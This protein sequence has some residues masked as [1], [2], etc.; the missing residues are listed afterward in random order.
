MRTLDDPLYHI[1]KFNEKNPIPRAYSKTQSL[2]RKVTNDRVDKQLSEDDKNL[3]RS[4]AEHR[5]QQFKDLLVDIDY[6]EEITKCI[7]LE[8]DA[9]FDPELIYNRNECVD[10]YKEEFKFWIEA[11]VMEDYGPILQVSYKVPP[12]IVSVNRTEDRKS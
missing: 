3:L 9:R 7:R 1:E 5:L 11:Q 12:L 10:Y 8:E 4:Y 6:E 2:F